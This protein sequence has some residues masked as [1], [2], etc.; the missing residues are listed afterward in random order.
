MEISPEVAFIIINRLFGGLISDVDS[1]RQFTEI[2][3]ALIERV[4]QQVS[5]SYEEAW[6]KFLKINVRVERLETSM[7]FAQITS[8]NE[9]VAVIAIRVSV[10]NESGI[11]SFCIPHA[12]AESVAKQF[13][14]KLLYS[15]LSD[16]TP[17]SKLSEVISEKLLDSRVR[18][19]ALFDT[20]TAT[21]ADIMH[22][23]EGDVIRLAHKISEP[24]TVNIEHLP[25]FRATIGTL[26]GQ[27]AIQIQEIIPENKRRE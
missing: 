14:T 27:S 13:N 11:I 6:E 10:G 16:V 8:P 7:Q 15:G 20:T 26:R 5:R 9:P 2:E 24:L 18:L 25:K 17:D 19:T 4:L 23:H 21:I 22:L 1:N 3:L 12:S